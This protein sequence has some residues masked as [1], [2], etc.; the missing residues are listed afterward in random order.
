MKS[1]PRVGDVTRETIA[2]EFDDRGPDVCRAEIIADLEANNPG[3][4]RHSHTVR[5]MFAISFA[6]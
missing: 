1:L 5:T 2:R 3:A 6:S 4:A